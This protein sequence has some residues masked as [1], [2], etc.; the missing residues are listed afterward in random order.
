M[1]IANAYKFGYN[2]PQG[3]VNRDRQMLVD[4]LEV[5]DIVRRIWE[6]A[7]QSHKQLL[8][9]IYINLLREFPDALDV[10][11]AQHLLE[12]PT[13]TLIWKHLLDETEGR[14]FYYSEA[15]YAQVSPLQAILFVYILTK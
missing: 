10:G 3:K 12:K 1:I 14:H 8:L 13:R 6:A 9:P 7:F 4:R 2:F 15:S 5:A 11:F